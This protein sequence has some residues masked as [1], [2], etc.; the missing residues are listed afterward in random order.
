[1]ATERHGR[2]PTERHRARTSSSPG[3]PASGDLDERHHGLLEVHRRAGNAAVGSLLGRGT[4]DAPVVA[5]APLLPGMMAAQ[6]ASEVRSAVEEVAAAGLNTS[7]I[8]RLVDRGI[9]DPELLTNIALWA[10]HPDTRYS[11]P[12]AAEGA[13]VEA[14]DRLRQEVVDPVLPITADRLGRFRSD[15]AAEFR[16]EVFRRQRQQKI[17][18]GKPFRWG[19]GDD[20]LEPILGSSTLRLHTDVAG[21]FTAMWEAAR[22]DLGRDRA[23]GEATATQTSWIRVGSAY[24]SSA[25]DF[26]AWRTAFANNYDATVDE[27]RAMAG[28][29]HGRAATRFMVRRMNARKAAP[30][31]SNHTHGRAVDVRTRFGT[32]PVLDA[33]GELVSGGVYDFGASSAQS[34]GW[35]NTWLWQWLD[36]HAAAHN[37]EPYAP[38]P[39][40]WNHTSVADIE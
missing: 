19:V 17:D 20:E 27:R 8:G 4:R 12:T 5:R 16:R 36:E 32:P 33:E 18:E 35:V 39:W 40:H 25:S 3:R 10:A 13:M 7:S 9:T 1:M 24:R 2:R 31:Y 14:R 6:V 21:D 34:A 28:G 29:E 22:A 15:G 38:E 30:G 37:F 26:E 11:V 23:R